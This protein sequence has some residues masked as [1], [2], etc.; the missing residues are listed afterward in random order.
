[1][2]APRVDRPDGGRPDGGRLDGGRLG[3]P[4]WRMY[5]A[6]ATA[7]LADGIGR[8]ALPLTAASYTRDP[9][10]ISGLVTFA[11]LPW[12]LFALPSGALIDRVDRRRAMAV[13]NGVRALAMVAL[14]ALVLCDTGGVAALYAVSFVLGVAET[15]YDSAVRA[16]LP[17]VVASHRLDRA[18]SLLTVE[19]TL[20]QTFFGAP[21]GSMLFAVAL[22]LPFVLD[23]AGFVVAALL[24]LTLRGNFRA[25]RTRRATVRSDVADGVRWLGAHRL[26]R[27][28]TLVSA[29]TAFALNMGNGVL[30]LYFLDVAHLPTGDYG[31]VLLVVGAGGLLGGLTTPPLTR[32]LGRAV[33]L[34]A[35]AALSGASTALMAATDDGVLGT[36]LLATSAAGVM[37][38]NVLAMSL[39]QA[40]VPGELFGR[41][42]GA[43][44]TLVWGAIP[45]GALAGGAL[46]AMAGVRVVFA[47]AGTLLLA[48][49][50]AL[51]LLL[52]RHPVD[53]RDQPNSA[54]V[55]G[56]GPDEV[57]PGAGLGRDGQRAPAPLGPGAEVGQAAASRD[58][59][60]PAPVV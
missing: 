16:L 44:R 53:L 21:L 42:Q 60:E 32:R 51:G 36:V 12:L 7:N 6:S 59:A 28:L 45:L 11:F 39:R 57:G 50:V 27:G 46:A 8:V 35:G 5:A 54:P 43:Y 58:V 48:L 20:G 38:W 4:F 3:A 17:Q 33:M 52:R 24:I 19:E 30:V 37:V 31:L 15:V 34:T 10:A 55:E 13:A 2:S 49:T 56:D 29:G 26:L 47:V 1:M 14:A 18:N 41:V 9:L 23:S 25:H 22:A 40:I